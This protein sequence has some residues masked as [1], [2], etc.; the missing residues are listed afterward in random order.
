MATYSSVSGRHGYAGVRVDI[1]GC[2]ESN[3]LLFD[4]YAERP[5]YHRR[6]IP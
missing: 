3:G 6:I 4:E 1:R 5:R 2:G